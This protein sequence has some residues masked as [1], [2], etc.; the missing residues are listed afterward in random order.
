MLRNVN[1][2]IDFRKIKYFV[3]RQGVVKKKGTSSIGV[4]G[5][6]APFFESGGAGAK[7]CFATSTPGSVF[8]IKHK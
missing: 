4:N 8:K 6:L 2:L 5:T 3:N 1:V 7:H